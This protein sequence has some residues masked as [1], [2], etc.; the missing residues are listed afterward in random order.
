MANLLQHKIGFLAGTLGQGGAERQLFYILRTLK[1]HGA[2]LRVLS[3]TQGEF[4]EEKIRALNVQIVWVGRSRSRL[5]RLRR[6]VSELR[7]DRPEIFQSQHFYTNLYVTAAAR[8]LGMREI[9][10]VRCDATSEV[11]G[12][13]RW[14]RRLS[15]RAP[16][17]IAANSRAAIRTAVALGVPA[18][19]LCLLP[20]VVDTGQFKPSASKKEP[21]LKLIA[22]GRL[23]EQKR[24]DRFLAVLARLRKMSALK[25]VIVGAGPLQSKLEQQ[26]RALGLSPDGVEFRGKDVD[27]AALYCE[28]DV[29][30]LTSDYEGTPNVVMEAMAAGLPVVSTRVGGVVDLVEHGASGFLVEPGDDEAL[31]KAL[32][33]LVND[34]TLRQTMG[35]RGREKI[36]PHYGLH[37]LPEFLVALYQQALA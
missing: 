32:L 1:E 2:R 11:A 4:W 34:A 6:I 20:N 18:K 7:V 31:L 24:L 9:A 21:P 16:R 33:E 23:T 3:L 8:A 14:L 35:E 26:A 19:R 13:G 22:V 15:L 10:A 37:R 17:L 28:A 27:M 5:G 30:V 25:G 29:L 12:A 36:E